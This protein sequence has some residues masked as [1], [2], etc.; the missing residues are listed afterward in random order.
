MTHFAKAVLI[1]VLVV[2]AA[3]SSDDDTPV[4]PSVL[5]E[6][7]RVLCEDFGPVGSF[8]LNGQVYDM[9]DCPTDQVSGG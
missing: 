2:G 8:P 6:I 9:S 4:D 1:P 3:C 5:A 7:E